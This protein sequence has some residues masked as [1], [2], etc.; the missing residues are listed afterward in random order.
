M[1]RKTLLDTKLENEADTDVIEDTQEKRPVGRPS[2][3]NDKIGTSLYLTPEM[4]RSIRL[5]AIDDNKK[6]NTV[7]EEAI[8]HYIDHRGNPG[9]G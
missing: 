7:I 4:K 2:G 1:A 3:T 5:I 6:M 9:R 8:Q